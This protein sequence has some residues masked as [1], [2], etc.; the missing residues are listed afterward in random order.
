MQPR[1]VI[2]IL[3]FLGSYF[4]L[5][6]ILL[7]QDFQY[8]Y[9]GA[10]FCFSAPSSGCEIPLKN[11]VY[12]LG[13]LLVTLVSFV[14]S[15]ITMASINISKPITILNSKPIPAELMSYALPYVVSFMSLDYQEVGRLLG[16]VVFLFWMF[17]ITYRSGQLILNPF[18]VVF[19]WKLYEIQYN[20]RTDETKRHGYALAK[21]SPESGGYW[22]SGSVQDV[23]AI[24]PE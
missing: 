14:A 12:S 18:L 9:F 2:S 7:V 17:L 5:S 23:L 8:E 3:I 10:S 16:L 22:L 13:I 4:P 1:L 24:K 6:I 15:L 11:P 20:Y 19:G 21:T